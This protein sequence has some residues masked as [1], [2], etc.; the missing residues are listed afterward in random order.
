MPFSLSED[1]VDSLLDKL[2]SDDDF[3]G[4]FQKDPR[5]ALAAVGHK[6][7]LDTSVKEG[8]WMCMSVSQ[9][10]SKEAIKASRDS[11]RK[12]FVGAKVGYQPINLEVSKR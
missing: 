11:L 5:A 2:S 3:R 4:L 8:A 7:A 10:A 12:Q 6:P 9:L 1:T